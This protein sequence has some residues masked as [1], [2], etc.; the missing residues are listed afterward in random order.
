M[1]HKPSRLLRHA[2]IAVNL[3]GT[4]SIPGVGDQPQHRKPFVETDRGVFHDRPDLDGKLPFGV[5]I[6]TL[7]A[8]LVFEESDVLLP[9]VGQTTT[10]SG[11]RFAA[12]VA[13]AVVL[14]FEVG[15]RFQ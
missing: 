15:E 8:L 3:P 7:P 6:R 10:P 2:E 1:E 13:E 5:A 14:I 9:H 12:K 4:D 11:Q